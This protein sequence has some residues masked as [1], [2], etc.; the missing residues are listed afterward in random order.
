MAECWHPGRGLTLL[1]ALAS[2]LARQA[3]GITTSRFHFKLDQ[4]YEVGVGLEELRGV[5]AAFGD[6]SGTQRTDLL[7]T[8]ADQTTLEL[9]EWVPAS[10]VFAHKPS[11][12]IKLADQQEKN[13]WISNVI[14]GDFNMDGKLDVIIQGARTKSPTGSFE[15]DEV[16]MWLYY[17]DGESG[18]RLAETLDSAAGALPFVL[19]YSGNGAMDLLGVP[20]DADV[21]AGFPSPIGVWARNPDPDASSTEEEEDKQQQPSSQRQFRLVAF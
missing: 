5:P 4:L 11:A 17:G 20:F 7:V 6:F 3:R 1:L 10:R 2:L 19:D 8:S 13:V 9:W 21:A 15:K 16:P 18:F 12:D 14:A